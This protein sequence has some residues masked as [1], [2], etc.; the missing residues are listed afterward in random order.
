VVKTAGG[1]I[2]ALA[3]W[4]PLMISPNSGLRGARSVAQIDDTFSQLLARIGELE[5]DVRELKDREAIRVLRCTYHDLTNRGKIPELPRL[6]A[7]DA[8]ID[9]AHMGRASGG[10]EIRKLFGGINTSFVKQFSHNHVIEVSG[11]CGIGYS[12]FEAKL[13]HRGESFMVAGRFDDEYVRRD[14]RWLF[15][16]VRATFYF[17]VPLKEGWAGED[18]IKIRPRASAS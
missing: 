9:Y 11:D 3:L 10:D 14:G 8:E 1:R 12:Y 17:M 7:E 6:F 13:V 18:R 2:K 4:P 16:K 5:A 15:K